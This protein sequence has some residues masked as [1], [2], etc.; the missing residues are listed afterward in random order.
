MHSADCDLQQL[1]WKV[2][3][4]LKLL[5]FLFSGKSTWIVLLK[6][7]TEIKIQV[8]TRILFE[9][10]LTHPTTKIMAA[11][12]KLKWMERRC[13]QTSVEKI[14][15]SL[16]CFELEKC[17]GAAACWG[18]CANKIRVPFLRWGRYSPNISS[19]PK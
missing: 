14:L 16:A 17:G 19:T 11:M 12:E 7:E 8:K 4:L 9:V 3:L 18:C 10:S 1:D 6:Q 13:N 15:V 2:P 5:G